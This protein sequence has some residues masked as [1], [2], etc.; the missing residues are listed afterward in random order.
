VTVASA[1]IAAADCNLVEAYIKAGEALVAAKAAG[2]H[3]TWRSWLAQNFDQSEDTAERAM[4][5]WH[6]RDELRAEAARVRNFS[7][8]KAMDVIA[9]RRAAEAPPRHHRLRATPSKKVLQERIRT[10]ED[11]I[12]LK[13]D[14]IED[15]T[16]KL[17]VKT[18]AV[19]I[20]QS[21]AAEGS[22]IYDRQFGPLTGAE[23]VD[24]LDHVRRARRPHAPLPD[25]L[26]KLLAFHQVPLKELEAAE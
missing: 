18:E 19:V 9:D 11:R 22:H 14:A 21:A 7:V 4:K 2:P 24:I 17:A 12:I 5:F 3:G 23:W 26:L 8:R 10:L 6:H 25:S 1:I 16:N 13:N 20:E 15:L